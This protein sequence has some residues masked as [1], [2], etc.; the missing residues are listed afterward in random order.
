MRNT[1]L[2]TAIRQLATGALFFGMRS[3]EYSK[4]QGDRKTRLLQLKNIRFFIGRKEIKKSANMNLQ[5]ATLISIT[6]T[7]QKNG[8]KEADITMHRSRSDLCPVKIWGEIVKR[9][10]SYPKTNLDTP[11]NYVLLNSKAK[12]IASK[13][14]LKQILLTV[15]LIG[16]DKLGFTS[17]AVGT[18]SIR[19][20]FAMLL[21]QKGIRSDRIML[22]GRWRS[23]AFLEYIRPQVLEF[24]AGLSEIMLQNANFYTIPE[25]DLN[26]RET[27]LMFNPNDPQMTAE[28][29]VAQ[30][31]ING[32]RSDQSIV[33]PL[34][35]A[36]HVH[37]H[38]SD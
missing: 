24:S 4:V 25:N 3:C 29:N 11:V 15:T 19:S 30:P 2:S 34:P 6:F 36:A 7:Q 16:S 38:W 27:N 14:V 32:P 35:P 12:Y 18:H 28:L 22:Q 26:L 33:R 9:I 20:S 1:E 10:L 17:D 13:D 8:Q 21:Y 31:P 23:N 5:R 37:L